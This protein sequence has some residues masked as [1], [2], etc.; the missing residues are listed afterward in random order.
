MKLRHSIWKWG[1]A[2]WFL[3]GSR[4][5]FL[6]ALLPADKIISAHDSCTLGLSGIPALFSL[7]GA[8]NPPFAIFQGQV[9]I[10]GISV[11]SLWGMIHA[12][13]FPISCRVIL[14]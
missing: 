8:D 11:D 14:P 3:M 6:E 10:L 2:G 13:N 4:F 9:E 12:S 7:P 1:E 5:F